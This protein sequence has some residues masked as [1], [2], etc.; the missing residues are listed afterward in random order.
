MSPTATSFPNLDSACPT[1]DGE[2][3]TVR[4]QP[5]DFATRRGILQ[6]VSQVAA[7]AAAVEKCL[8]VAEG[9]R[10]QASGEPLSLDPDPPVALGDADVGIN[11]SRSGADADADRRTLIWAT[12]SVV[13]HQSWRAWRLSSQI[14]SV[15]DPRGGRC[16]P[17]IS[18]SE[19]LRRQRGLRPCPG[20]RREPP[21]AGDKWRIPASYE[22]MWLRWWTAS[23]ASTY[24]QPHARS[25]TK[26]G[27]SS[28]GCNV[29]QD[30]ATCSFQT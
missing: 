16:Q 21:T 4:H 6:E 8:L 9:H 10:V 23:Q 3:A 13:H 29:G 18:I 17:A 30:S 14:S 24:V 25:L 27:D 5:W 28:P 2:F 7:A 26:H 15:P 19:T 22:P 11:R 20:N 12:G 1:A